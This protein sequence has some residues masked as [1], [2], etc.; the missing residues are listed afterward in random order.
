MKPL[1]EMSVVVPGFSRPELK[2]TLDALY[3]SYNCPDSAT[4]PIQIVRR[5]ETRADREIAGFCAAAL[6][7]GRVGS[8]M[9]S[10]G[11]L[12]GAMGPSPEAFVRSFDPKRDGDAL[13]P[14]VHRWTR[15]DDFVALVWILREMLTRAG[16]IERFFLEGCNDSAADLG[17]AI[18]SFSSRVRQI[19]LRCAYRRR[20]ARPGVYYF[21]PS[22]SSGSACKR[23]NLFLRWMVRS[24]RIDLGVWSRVSPSRL[25]VPLDTN[26]VRVGRC[27]GLTRRSSPG[28]KMAAD[29][30][31]TLREM[32]PIDPVKYDFSLCHAG[33]KAACGATRRARAAQCPLGA[34]CRPAARR[35]RSSRAPSGRR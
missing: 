15:G 21:F 16:S 18:E 5:Y 22:P 33:M 11:Q 25:I 10:I 19:D 35:S 34:F 30:T 27:L 2:R 1:V 9:K 12:L 28:W 3:A 7:F 8:I 20:L 17:P 29:I 6:A 23:M 14:M 4:D 31:R 13:R 32:D 24:D 26:V